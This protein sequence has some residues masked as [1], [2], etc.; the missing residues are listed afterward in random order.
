MRRIGLVFACWLCATVLATGGTT[1]TNI[2]TVGGVVY[3]NV[4]VRRVEPDGLTLM[5]S[6]GVVKIPFTGLSTETQTA[7]GYD[8]EKASTYAEKVAEAQR[9]YAQKQEQQRAQDAKKAALNAQINAQKQAQ[10]QAQDAKKAALNAQIEEGRK[11]TVRGVLIVKIAGGLLVNCGQSL[12]FARTDMGGASSGGMVGGKQ[13]KNKPPFVHGIILLTGYPRDYRLVGGSFVGAVAY[14]VGPW[15]YYY[16][17][18][19]GVTRTIE[20]YVVSSE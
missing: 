3:S 19:R 5:R 9:K 6:N 11:Y 1:K 12:D 10:E 13:K 20:Q 14:K 7:Y 16:V 8:P 18:G 2:T 15:P 17:D 4:V